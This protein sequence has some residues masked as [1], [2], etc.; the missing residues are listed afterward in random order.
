MWP[1]ALWP[2]FARTVRSVQGTVATSAGLAFASSSS[3]LETHSIAA[4]RSTTPEGSVTGPDTDAGALSAPQRASSD[5][6]ASSS[7]VHGRRTV[8]SRLGPGH[9]ARS[10]QEQRARHHGNGRRAG[11]YDVH[12][13]FVLPAPGEGRASQRTDHHVGKAEHSLA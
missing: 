11:G 10:L 3:S 4:W 7:A 12:Q 2:G 6:G 5:A 13:Y 9:A 8:P 1:P